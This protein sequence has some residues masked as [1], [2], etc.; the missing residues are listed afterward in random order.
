MTTANSVPQGGQIR[1]DLPSDVSLISSSAISGGSCRVYSCSEANTGADYIIFTI[2]STGEFSNGIEAG[3]DLIIDLVGVIN[4]RTTEPTGTFHISTFDD[5]ETPIDEGYD[6]NT[7]MYFLG[8]LHSFSA[9]QTNFVNGVENR[10]IFSMQSAVPLN[11]GDKLSFTFP[12]DIVPP[13]TS[14][15][16]NCAIIF[17]FEEIECNISGYSME[18]KFISLANPTGTF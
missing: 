8:Q 13:S 10:Y 15:E 5:N 17:G 16:L 3:S 14:E 7:Q 12:T 2:P 4:P 11:S 1:I 18:I 9:I 6:V